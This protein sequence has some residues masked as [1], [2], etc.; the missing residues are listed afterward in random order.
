[1]KPNMISL[2]WYGSVEDI[3]SLTVLGLISIHISM[4]APMRLDRSKRLEK[5]LRDVL[6]QK[7]D[8]DTFHL[9][10]VK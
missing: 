9:S 7:V 3:V 10:L 8:A 1:M 5:L 2:S 4:F 6:F